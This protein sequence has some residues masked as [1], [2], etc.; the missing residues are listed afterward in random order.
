VS[1]AVVRRLLW[2]VRVRFPLILLFVALWGFALVALFANADDTTRTAGLGGNVSV[3]FRLAGLDPLTI[4]TVLG[5]T[6]PVFLV[7]AFLFVIGLGVRSVAGELEGGGLD[8]SLARPITRVRY[9]GSH[10]VVLIPGAALLAV[11]YV[12]GTVT[13]DRIFGPPGAPLQID[14]MLLAAVQAWV[15]FASIGVLTL[16]VSTLM[17]ERGRALAVSIGIVLVM[18]VGN[19]LF[20]LWEP[21]RPLTRVTLFW[22]FSPGP[23]IQNGDFPWTNVLVLTGCSVVGAIVALRVFRVRDLAR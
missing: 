15:L 4:W 3:A 1:G 12:I 13:A 8:L 5:Q 16:V 14:R 6:H 10:L 19:F 20:A 11:A 9:L 22:W 2:D 23:T 18:Y 17:S 7:T 21:L